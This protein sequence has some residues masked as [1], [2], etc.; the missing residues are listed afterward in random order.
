M[1]YGGVIIL[2]TNMN[3]W[4]KNTMYFLLDIYLLQISSIDPET[5]FFY[6]GLTLSKQTI[7]VASSPYSVFFLTLVLWVFEQAILSF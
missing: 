4:P 6:L 2:K 1:C 3:K 5:H 7:N